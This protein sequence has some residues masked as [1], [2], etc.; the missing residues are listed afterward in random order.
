MAQTIGLAVVNLVVVVGLAPLAEGITRRVRA[1]VHSRKGP[2]LVQPYYDLAKLLVKEEL[3]PTGALTWRLAPAVCLGAVLM[4]ALLIPLGPPAPL[5]AAGDL[6]VF[7]Y[8]L[9]LA[10]AA[11]MLGAFASGNPYAYV[12]ASREMMMM[13]SVEPVMAIALITA[14]V[15]AHSLTFS[16]IIGYQAAAGTSLSMVVAGV[17]FLLALQAQVGKLPFDIAEAEQEIMEGPYIERSGP[18]LALFKL[19]AYAKMLILGSV[20]VQVFIPLP[21]FHLWIANLAL[22]LGALAVLVLVVGLVNAVNPRLRID[23]SM[24]YFSRVVVFVA[25]GGLI[26]ASIGA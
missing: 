20:L 19:A 3:A 14:A 6:I 9:A 7:I 18:G 21:R 11:V 1:I 16:G 10:A 25:L 22:N 24:S 23:Q 12:G 26:F 5:A 4:A 17:A 8:F 13:F 2:P 15:K